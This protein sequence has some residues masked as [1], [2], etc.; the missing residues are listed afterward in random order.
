[1]FDRADEVGL[2]IISIDENQEMT[3]HNLSKIDG[4]PFFANGMLVH[5]FE[6]Q[7]TGF[8]RNDTATSNSKRTT[9]ARCLLAQ[10]LVWTHRLIIMSHLLII[11]VVSVYL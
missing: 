2:E 6:Q 10:R 11:I 5:N 8:K 7:L 1:M 9:T 3:V 4:N